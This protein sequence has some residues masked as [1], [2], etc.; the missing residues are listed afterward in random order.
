MDAQQRTRSTLSKQYSPVQ[1]IGNP[2]RARVAAGRNRRG[3]RNLGRSVIE[4]R[5]LD[6]TELG[7]CYADNECQLR[8]EFGIVS[9]ALRSRP[10][11]IRPLYWSR[12]VGADS[13]AVVSSQAFSVVLDGF[14]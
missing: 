4:P 10:L 5:R 12:S 6:L 3:L 13:R 7:T 14:F 11:S 2:R 1:S 8:P 9:L